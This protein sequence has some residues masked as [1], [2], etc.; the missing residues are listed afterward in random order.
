ML[1]IT[2]HETVPFADGAPFAETGAY[3]L[4]NGRVDFRIDPADPAQAAVTDI[5][6]APRDADGLVALS[7]DV[8]ILRPA[9]PARGNGRLFFDYGNR[10]NKRALQ[11]FN[12]APASNDLRTL[13]DA[14]NG[15]LMRRGYTIAWL[16][17]QGDLLPGDGR[18]L[19]DVP[20][21][22]DGGEPITGVTRAE[23]IAVAEGTTT[24]PLSTLIS[25]RSNPAASLDTTKARLTRRRFAMSEREEIAP[26]RWAFARVDRGGGVDNQGMERAVIPSDSHIHLPE[27]FVPGWIYEL[28]YQ[29]KDPRI[30]G[31]AHVAVRD[32]VDHLKSGAADAA[33]NPSPVTVDTA[34]AWGRSQTGRCIRDF[35]HLGFND[36]GGRRVFDGV[37]PHVAGAGKMWMNHRFANVVLLPG[38]EHENHFTPA[39]RFPFAYAVSTDH[40]TGI[41]DGICKR[42]ETDPKVMHTDT[43]SE[44]WHRRASLVV[45]D[46]EG[47]DLAPPDNVRVYLWASSQH[48][49]SPTATPT[50]GL[51][52]EP[53]N[54]VATSAFFRATLDALDAWVSEGTEPPAS[55]YPTV[56]GGTLVD[57]DTWRVAFPAIPG[58][59]T[60]RGPSTLERLDFGPEVERGII[61]HEPPRIVEGESY[62][63]LVPAV[64]ADGNDVAGVRAPMVEAPLAT[65]VGWSVRRR[66][67]GYGAMLG[68]TGS[69]LPFPEDDD[70]RAQLRDPRP[71]I[72]ARYG[73]AEAYVAAIR[74]AAE[75]LVAE[76]RML[77]EDVDRAADMAR[78][79]S[80][81]RHDLTLSGEPAPGR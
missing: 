40:F 28:V 36:A 77:A 2:I 31:L 57:V 29:A 41:T 3:E 22:T 79:W 80:R 56:A 71:S 70:E 68:I 53:I 37:L 33:G 9:D 26:D 20:V 52:L 8:T 78:D 19:L 32:F 6:Y 55:R 5:A 69:T 7:A 24:F 59:V 18:M 10:G 61:A 63:V 35:L 21:A 34:Y 54:V 23:Y 39:D 76:R 66:G 11:F 47:R 72:L 12:D 64:D 44:Y 50:T 25:T 42:P 67:A 60:P 81:P 15:F 62:P 46:T 45:T 4:L 43:A 17:W 13:A 27:S 74:A 38:Q 65:Y 48:F 14:G 75:A 30:L 1:T 16:G 49:A 73:S 51:A 58:V